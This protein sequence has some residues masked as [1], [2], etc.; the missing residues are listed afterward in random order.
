MASLQEITRLSWACRTDCSREV[1][2]FRFGNERE[3]S[4]GKKPGKEIFIGHLFNWSIPPDL[5]ACR[6]RSIADIFV[7]DKLW[8]SDDNDPILSIERFGW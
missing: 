7:C 2:R 1:D 4:I 5:S 8:L 6:I 3:E